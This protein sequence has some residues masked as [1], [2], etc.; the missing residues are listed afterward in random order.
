M[1]TGRSSPAPA[2]L[3]AAV[4]NAD[5]AS[6]EPFQASE[7]RAYQG[8][9]IAILKAGAPSG[10]ITLTASAPGLAPGSITIEVVAAR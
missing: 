6:H 3:I 7:R 4:D 9:A 8:R 1:R 10:R 2:G 5:N